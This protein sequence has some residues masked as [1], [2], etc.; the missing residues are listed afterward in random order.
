MTAATGGA[1]HSYEAFAQPHHFV[2]GHRHRRIQDLLHQVQHV[3]N[4]FPRLTRTSGSKIGQHS[5]LSLVPAAAGPK[6]S[7]F[8]QMRLA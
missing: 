3:N 2:L 1:A 7:A 6:V 4:L 8:F 5:I